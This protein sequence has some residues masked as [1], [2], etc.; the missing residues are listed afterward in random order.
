[1]DKTTLVLAIDS[2]QVG[3]AAAAFERMVGAGNAAAAAGGKVTAGA[4]A[5]GRAILTTMV[6]A[7]TKGKIAFNELAAAAERLDPRIA[8]PKSAMPLAQGV[9]PQ[10]VPQVQADAVVTEP[11]AKRARKTVTTD[12]VDTS[13]AGVAKLAAE[14][15]KAKTSLDGLTTSARGTG[16][17]LTTLTSRARTAA[18]AVKSISTAPIKAP[19]GIAAI[20]D[21]ASKVTPV[22]FNQV[23]AAMA[24]TAAQAAKTASAVADANRA[25]AAP[26]Q[27][28]V[29]TAAPSA[30]TP[31]SA[32]A[33]LSAATGLRIPTAG[34]VAQLA[35]DAGRAQTAV[36]RLTAAARNQRSTL[37]QL[38][39]AAA[40]TAVSYRQLANTP[41]T[42]AAPQGLSN[43]AAALAN[44]T[45]Q[46]NA[47][48]VA[49]AGLNATR[50]PAT[51]QASGALGAAGARAATQQNNA[52]GVSARQ[53][54]FQQQQLAFQLNDFFV[55]VASG[56]S[57]LTALIQQGSQLSGTFG[58]I[59]N[60]VRAVTGLLAPARLAFGGAAASVGALG[61]AFHESQQR[62]YAFAQSVALSGNYA[63]QTEG[64]VN[65]LAQAVSRQSQATQS[66][67]REMAQALI[68]TGKIGPEAFEKATEAAI[69]YQLAI[70]KTAEEVAKD[71][72]DM[73][74]SP[75]KFAA[76]LG[77]VSAK[78]L[79]LI[80]DLEANGDTARAVTIAYEAMIGKFQALDSKLPF[81]SERWKFLTKDIDNLRNALAGVFSPSVEQQMGQLEARIASLRKGEV[82][83]WRTVLNLDNSDAIR[84]AQA[85][86]DKLRGQKATDDGKAKAD[87]RDRK[88]KEASAA[89]QPLLDRA[90]PQ[91]VFER[92]QKA[93]KKRFGEMTAAGVGLSPADQEAAIEQLKKSILPTKSGGRSGGGGDASQ[94]LRAQLDKDLNGFQQVLER[95]RDSFA[96]HNRFLQNEYQAGAVSLR[97]FYNEKRDTAAAAGAAELAQL[98]KERIR[99]EQFK[100]ATKDPS[101]RLQTQTKLDGNA[102]QQE[103]VRVSTDRDLQLSNQE[104]I[105][106]FKAL[107]DQITNYRANLLQMQGDE[108]GAARLRAQSAISAAQVLAKQAAGL[109]GAP[110][111]ASVFEEARQVEI[112][113]QSNDVQRQASIL[114]NNSARAEEAFGLA[115]ERSGKTLAESERGIFEIRSQELTQL[116]ALTAKAKELA[117]AST[118][119]AVKQFAADIALEYAKAAA[120]IDPAL[121]RLRDANRELA[122]GL[123]NT[124]GNGPNAI[125]QEYT[126][127]RIDANDDIKRQR[128]EYSRKIDLLEGYLATTQDKNDKARLRARIKD[129]EGKRDSVKGE[130]RGSSVFKAINEAIIQPMAEQVFQTV[131][132]LL[133]TD[134]L[135]EYLKGQLTKLT[136]DKGP[137]AGIFQ[138]ALGIKASPKDAA[139]ALQT[140][141]IDANRAAMNALTQAAQ[142]A[143]AALSTPIPAA[144][145]LLPTGAPAL[146]AEAGSEASDSLL[147]MSRTAS[148]AASD[149]SRLAAAAGV[150]GEAMG[151]LPAIVNLFQSAAAAM[152]AA[153]SGG[154][155]SGIFGAIAGLFGGADAGGMGYESAFASSGVY[156]S[157]GV[158]GS[159][160]EKRSVA[161]SVFAGAAKYHTG[162]IAGKA[163]DKLKP[164]EVAAILMGGPKGTREE[165]ITADDPR[166]RD[167]LGMNALA[168]IMAE[169][170]HDGMRVRGARELGGPVSANGMYRVNEKGPE[171]L[172]VAGKQYLMTGSQGGSVTPNGGG[173]NS[174][175]TITL[176]VNVTPPAGAT[177]ASASQFGAAAGRQIRNSLRR[178][179]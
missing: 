127:R 159:A 49:I 75:A 146:S 148:S 11:K 116:G 81:F 8:Q 105:A 101:E 157:G 17:A 95:E 5:Q 121:N 53:A 160:P 68:A 173:S 70:G 125:A 141:A 34:T 42:L 97:D 139:T 118:V 19:V 152:T 62:G 124:A 36:E 126:R 61:L 23:T 64:K 120:A 82:M 21:A 168:K 169:S 137:L 24:L 73:A 58:G 84:E 71:F 18:D 155:S 13:A 171:L 131:N 108:A 110:T 44:A 132:K 43:A 113:I 136:E 107:N 165:V 144:G 143:A 38:A 166:H 28:R 39:P 29:T 45:T 150:G 117:D 147:A 72:A 16:N 37:T 154:S 142:A 93:L 67:V 33:P 69:R 119:P 87:A 129:A 130:S 145:D 77:A 31:L 162:G 98:E 55:Q 122:S 138:D 1:M 153:S 32:A 140:A 176:H 79:E 51:S 91:K 164:N 52:L 133:I 6:P 156:H 178:N 128:D 47:A 92:E 96:F 20:F 54:A 74:R 78:Q 134:P 167:N 149:V 109:P 175:N 63:G 112:Q 89:V 177:S 65:A 135:Q 151:R 85:K 76:S 14:S 30:R 15:K 48:R 40:A 66:D 3:T 12:S 115:A 59:G 94:I 83:D 100:K 60:A 41:I 174:G 90:N 158:V 161:Q 86:L 104:E 114:I 123:A 26:V 9:K 7:A 111:A 99:L 88:G 106:S 172:Q 80:R 2:T 46:A 22:G 50:A 103:K 27:I 57:P 10:P 179:T 170:K 4:L 102:A 25:I 56:G 35:G 163:A